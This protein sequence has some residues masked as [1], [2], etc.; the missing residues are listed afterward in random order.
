MSSST[1]IT[2]KYTF[3][4]FSFKHLAGSHGAS[5]GIECP[6]SLLAGESC[7]REGGIPDFIEGIPDFMGNFNTF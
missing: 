1:Y 5:N 7:F 2:H 6:F 4:L 3:A